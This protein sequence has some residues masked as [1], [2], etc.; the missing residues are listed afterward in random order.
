[1]VWSDGMTVLP[2]PLCFM[3]LDATRAGHVPEPDRLRYR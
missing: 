2:P 1:M 3:L